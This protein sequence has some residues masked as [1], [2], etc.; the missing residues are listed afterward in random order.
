MSKRIR[1]DTKLCANL[2]SYFKPGKNEELACHGYIVVQ[3]LLD[4]GMRISLAR[5]VRTVCPADTPRKRLEELVCGRCSF[6]EHDCDYVVTGGAAPSCG[7]LLLLLHLVGTGEISLD[8]IE[9]NT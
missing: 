6:R 7:G 9:R 3:R 4:S 2:C 1:T 8:E 5:P